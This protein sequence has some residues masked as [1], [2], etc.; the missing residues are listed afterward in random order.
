[1]NEQ[2]RNNIIDDLLTLKPSGEAGENP[3]YEERMEWCYD[4]CKD[5]RRVDCNHDYWGYAPETLFQLQLR[6]EGDVERYIIKRFH[7]DASSSYDL[8]SG[9]KAGVTRKKNRIWSRIRSGISTIL[10][11]GR[12][13]VYQLSQGYYGGTLGTVYATD[14][15]DA[16]KLGRMFYG[17]FISSDD[18]VMK[19]TF[20]KLGGIENIQAENEKAV[21]KLQSE[22]KDNIDKI[23]RL[24]TDNT[25]TEMQIDAIRMLQMHTL[26]QMNEAQDS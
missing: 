3:T 11:E 12:P 19:S 14:H 20:L 5:K 25:K 7:P 1:M 26:S 24:K 21:S 8:G 6:G 18:G 2:R 4:A 10:K 15:D 17:H 16:M 23:E 22:I 9:Q 13:G